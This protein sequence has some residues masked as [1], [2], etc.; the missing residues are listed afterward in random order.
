M[1]GIRKLTTNATM[2]SHGV[3]L[4]L[5]TLHVHVPKNNLFT[6]SFKITT[7]PTGFLLDVM[8]GLGRTVHSY[9]LSRITIMNYDVKVKR[10]DILEYFL[11]FHFTMWCRK[12]ITWPRLSTLHVESFA[13]E[14]HQENTCIPWIDCSFGTHFA[15]GRIHRLNCRWCTFVVHVNSGTFLGP[16]CW[17]LFCILQVVQ[18][19]CILYVHYFHTG[20]LFPFGCLDHLTPL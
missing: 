15:I 3:E 13:F 20:I 16:H 5:S 10:I 17:I 11:V 18:I 14:L 12:T 2:C 1:S 9:E 7:F 4:C 8:L 19:L 6:G